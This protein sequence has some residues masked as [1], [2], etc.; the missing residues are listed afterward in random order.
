MVF[1]WRVQQ[2]Q[3]LIGVFFWSLTLAL[4]AYQYLAPWLAKV[5]IP[6]SA[7]ALGIL[8]TLLMVLGTVLTIGYAYDRVFRLWHDQTVVSYER[9]PFARDRLT[10]Q[11]IMTYEH[12]YIPI[13]EE[14]E[15][16]R[17]AGPVHSLYLKGLVRH[18]LEADANIKREYERLLELAKKEA[19]GKSTEGGDPPGK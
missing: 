11:M 12:L 16:R 10:P 18:N 13:L 5:G 1:L 7:V 2:S 6:S 8:V 19:E 15:E 4:L 14:I 17:K 9:N 3:M